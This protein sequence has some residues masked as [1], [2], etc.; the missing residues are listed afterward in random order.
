MTERLSD[1]GAACRARGP[2]LFATEEDYVPMLQGHE[3][4]T[5]PR[6]CNS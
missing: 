5:E 3:Q 6:P 4:G 2:A 1:T